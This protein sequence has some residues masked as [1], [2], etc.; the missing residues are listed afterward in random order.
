MQLKN[1]P[2]NAISVFFPRLEMMDGVDEAK[3]RR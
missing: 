3:R 1:D 2:D